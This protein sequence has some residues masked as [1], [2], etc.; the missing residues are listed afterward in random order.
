V[1]AIRVHSNV[2]S[3]IE[4]VFGLDR[5]AD[6]QSF[7]SLLHR[8]SETGHA[9]NIEKP[10]KSR[11]SIPVISPQQIEAM[12]EVLAFVAMLIARE[13]EQRQRD[14]APAGLDPLQKATRFIEM[15]FTDK[16]RLSTVARAAGFSDDYFS[17]RFRE[18]I[19][20]SFKDYV[21]KRRIAHAQELLLKKDT[22]ISEVAFACGFESISHFNRSF[23][24]VTRTSPKLYRNAK[25][26]APS[27]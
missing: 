11:P 13:I 24:Q 21:A 12:S 15:N 26:L 16:L 4:S 1:V 14:A 20:V 6:A 3:F 25:R 2:L 19:G 27:Q 17:R 10:K 9:V 8:G 5:A 23:K 22:R 7:E 18:T